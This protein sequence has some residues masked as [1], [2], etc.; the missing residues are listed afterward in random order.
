M[1]SLMQF[2]GRM[3][4]EK[5]VGLLCYLVQQDNEF[6]ETEYIGETKHPVIYE[7]FRKPV[8]MWG[9]W[10]V[11]R[12]HGD[13]HAPDLSIPLRLVTLPKGAERV[14]DQAAL[15]YWLDSDWRPVPMGYGYERRARRNLLGLDVPYGYLIEGSD[16]P[17]LYQ[18]EIGRV[19]PWMQELKDDYGMSNFHTLPPGSTRIS[20]QAALR[21]WLDVE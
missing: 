4:R 17:A 5:G 3:S 2:E 8:G 12:Y 16:L 9:A 21:C 10:V 1:S 15:R 11:F 20:D 6:Q 19:K 18:F 14:P 13:T 7:F